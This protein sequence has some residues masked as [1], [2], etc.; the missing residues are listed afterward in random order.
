MRGLYRTRTVL[1]M[2]L[3]AAIPF[4][5][6]AFFFWGEVDVI[7]TMAWL[8]GPFLQAGNAELN[9]KRKR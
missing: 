4:A 5:I 7:F 1:K 6:W 8:I 3:T 9:A 2:V